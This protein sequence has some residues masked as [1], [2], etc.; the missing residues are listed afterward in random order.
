MESCRYCSM[1]NFCVRTRMV[2]E[3]SE[4][5]RFF[6]NFAVEFLIKTYLLKA[7]RCTWWCNDASAWTWSHRFCK[8]VAWKWGVDEKIPNHTATRRA[9]QHKTWTSQ[10]AR[11]NIWCSFVCCSLFTLVLLLCV[12]YI[13]MQCHFRVLILFT[14]CFAARIYEIV[15]QKKNTY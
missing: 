9:V 15:Q 10:H 7:T 2:S 8:I 14:S 1:W 6:C 5:V 13:G 3:A 12:L 11:V 4:Y